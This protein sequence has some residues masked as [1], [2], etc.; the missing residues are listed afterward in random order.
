MAKVNVDSLMSQFD[1][2]QG[3]S[4]KLHGITPGGKPYTMFMQSNV[5]QVLI[6][7]HLKYSEEEKQWKAAFSKLNFT[8]RFT[9]N[10]LTMSASK[11]RNLEERLQEVF[12]MIDR[13]D[14]IVNDVCPICQKGNCDTLG[15][16]SSYHPTHKTCLH[17]QKQA[18]VE[19]LESNEG[20]YLTGA[21]GAFLGSLLI[22]LLGLVSIVLIQVS[23][24]I[25]FA[26]SGLVGAWGYRKLKGK[27]GTAARF[28]ICAMSLLAFV[29]FLYCYAYVSL[30]LYLETTLSLSLFFNLIPEITSIIFSV[31]FLS[32]CW[33]E[34]LFFVIG[35]GLA[36][37]D[38]SLNPTFL[39]NELEKDNQIQRVIQLQ[40]SELKQEDRFETIE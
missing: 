6:P 31:D 37:L 36:W 7:V 35:L 28:L 29:V 25:I 21:I 4:S 1:L 32:T 11:H 34:I 9:E 20:N 18:Q 2:K 19:Q 17:K 8:S 10:G 12:T 16:T 40:D 33:F 23:Y 5:W 26:C 39:L 13:R 14:F 38:R 15:V 3:S 30:C 27:L 22:T 24:G